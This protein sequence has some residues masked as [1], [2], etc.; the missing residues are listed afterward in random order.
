MNMFPQILVIGS[1]DHLVY[2]LQ[3]PV[4]YFLDIAP[5][6]DLWQTTYH[7]TVICDEEAL[8]WLCNNNDILVLLP[9][10]DPGCYPINEFT[11]WP[12][13]TDLVWSQVLEKL[14]WNCQPCHSHVC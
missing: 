3:T 13:D 8:S 5:W 1:Q 14:R 7:K 9:M 2:A 12:A 11:M 4:G 6:L 10:S